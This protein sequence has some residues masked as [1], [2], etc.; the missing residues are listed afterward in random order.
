M[1]FDL[2][3]EGQDFIT[4]FKFYFGSPR[5]ILCI[6]TPLSSMYYILLSS[7]IFL[8]LLKRS[9]TF[10]LKFEGQ[11]FITE[12]KFYFGSPSGRILCILTPI[13]SMY[14]ILLPSYIFSDIK[15]VNDLWPLEKVLSPPPT[16]PNFFLVTV[17]TH[18][19][20]KSVEKPFPR[21]F[22]QIG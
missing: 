4:E 7:H 8:L 12:S 15:K 3:F 20:L 6:L 16:P 18:Y 10:D 14:Y 5:R 21:I 22:S 9:M 19:L 2:K 13:S 17:D 1:T 11:D